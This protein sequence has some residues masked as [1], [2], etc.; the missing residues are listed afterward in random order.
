[1]LNRW[2]NHRI[3]CNQRQWCH[4][5]SG[6]TISDL[7]C[8]RTQQLAACVGKSPGGRLF[9]VKVKWVAPVSSFD[10]VRAVVTAQLK[11]LEMQSEV[12]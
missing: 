11:E 4:R 1:M 5:D 6:P 9:T 8:V 2:Q 3:N 10:R 12:S 7:T